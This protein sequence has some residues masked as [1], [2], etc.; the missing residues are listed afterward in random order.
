MVVQISLFFHFTLSNVTNEIV[1]TSTLVRN[2]GLEHIPLILEP[3][4]QQTNNHYVSTLDTVTQGL[5]A[6]KCFCV[7]N[8]LLWWLLLTD[9]R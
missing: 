6:K 7:S 3:E 9:D 5:H 2:N 8:P 4:I 1:N